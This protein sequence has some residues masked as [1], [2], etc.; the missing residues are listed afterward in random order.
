[1][2][3]REDQTPP[4]PLARVKGVG[5]QHLLEFVFDSVY[6]DLQYDV[7]SLTFIAGFVSL[8]GH[9]VVFGRSV[10]L[11]WTIQI[12]SKPPAPLNMPFLS[13]QPVFCIQLQTPYITSP[14]FHH[15]SS[16]RLYHL[17]LPLL[18]TVVIGSTPI[19]LLILHLSFC[20]S[21]KH[22]TFS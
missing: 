14:T 3:K 6:V 19:S 15:F 17:S 20:H 16:L 21:W 1:M 18:L 13:F 5:R 7:I 8:C 22:D 12:V 9:V 10:R 4:P 2:D 11:S